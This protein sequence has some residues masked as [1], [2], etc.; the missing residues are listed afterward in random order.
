VPSASASLVLSAC[1][2]VLAAVPDELGEGV[3]RRPVTGDAT[4]TAA[5]GSPPV[6]LRCGVPLP[7]QTQPPLVIDGFA[8]VVEERGNAVTYTTADRAVNAAVVVPKSYEDQAYLVQALIPALRRLPDPTA[9]P[10]A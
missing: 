1:R 3:P 10:G 8:L 7:G 4:R 6:T 2:T 9:A 5:W